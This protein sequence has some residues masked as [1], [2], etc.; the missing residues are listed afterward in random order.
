MVRPTPFDGPEWEGWTPFGET[1]VHRRLDDIRLLVAYADGG[2]GIERKGEEIAVAGEK[3][4]PEILALANQI[5]EANGGW[6]DGGPQPCAW[7]TPD[8]VISPGWYWAERNG[9]TFVVNVVALS[10]REL[11]IDRERSTVP[12]TDYT[13]FFGPI[14]GPPW[15]REA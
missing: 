13:R 7:L 5:A 8:Q 12:L 3:P 9:W 2:L 14:P 1:E 11:R 10:T 4:L 15:E 6:A